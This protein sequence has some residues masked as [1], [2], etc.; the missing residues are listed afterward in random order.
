MSDK[1]AVLGNKPLFPNLLPIIQPTLPVYGAIAPQVNEIMGNGMLTKGKYLRQFEEQLAGYLGVRHAVCVSS[2]TLGLALTYQGLG[3]GGEVIVPSFTFMATVHPLVWL[4]VS[5]VFAEIDPQTW[6]IDPTRVEEAI[7]PRATGIVAVHNFGNPAAIEALQAIARRH[8]LKLVFDAA[9]G[10][11][12]LYQGEPV[13]RYG[14]AEVFSATPTKLLVAGEGGVVTTDSGVLAEHIRVGREYG[15]DGNYGSLFA[16]L[17][18][19]MPEFNA[20]LGLKS[21]EML[22]ENAE[23]RNRVVEL[24]REHLEQL[25]GLTFQTILPG[26]RCSYKDLS[27][28]V[29]GDEFGIT[30]DQLAHALRVEN[31]DTRKYHDPPVHTHQ[32]YRHRRERYDGRLPTTDWVAARSL[33][34]PIWSHMDEATILGICHA[35]ERIHESA[36]EVAVALRRTATA[37]ST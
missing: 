14:D 17:N 10:F 21:L 24:F 29:D 18:A 5:P 37:P 9:H 13:G 23:K 35:V 34:L 1:P 36:G 4:G 19:R 3:L 8:G 31:I 33:S 26:N 32:T 30:R 28:L 7:T 11:G 16:G 20:I 2:C 25:P 27:V 6:C 12:A 15:N 22:E